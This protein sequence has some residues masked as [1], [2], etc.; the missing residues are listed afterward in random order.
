MIK[1]RME[2]AQREKR[3]PIT[4]QLARRAAETAGRG[5]LGFG[6]ADERFDPFEDETPWAAF[7]RRS[8]MAGH[9][10]SI[11]RDEIKAGWRDREIGAKA[12]RVFRDPAEMD[13]WPLGRRE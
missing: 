7:S 1:R 11:D 12:A 2:V 6:G 3:T 10:A 5:T 9:A 8:A 13:A 4:P